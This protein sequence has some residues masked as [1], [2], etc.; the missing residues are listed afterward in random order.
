M[1]LSSLWLVVSGM[2][3]PISSCSSAR[4]GMVSCRYPCARGITPTIRPLGRT[5]GDD[6]GECPSLTRTQARLPFIYFSLIDYL[7]LVLV[8]VI[9]FV[10]DF[11]SAVVKQSN[12]CFDWVIIY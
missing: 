1:R 8:F 10:N 5:N 2:S 4:A 6:R 11:K 3:R 7:F 12:F 9:I